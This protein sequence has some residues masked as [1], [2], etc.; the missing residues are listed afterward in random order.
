MICGNYTTSF[1]FYIKLANEMQ[2][3]IEWEG[4]IEED[5]TDWAVP[6]ENHDQSR[7]TRDDPR[8][9]EDESIQKR[10]ISN[11]LCTHG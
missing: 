11:V 4:A 7:L 3:T 1:E 2:V 9:R 5:G 6:E 8:P 10:F